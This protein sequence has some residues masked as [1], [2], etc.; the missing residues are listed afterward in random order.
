MINITANEKLTKVLKEKGVDHYGPAYSGESV[1]L[2]LYYTGDAVLVVS[3]GRVLNNETREVVKLVPTGLRVALPKKWVGLILDRGSISKTDLIRR[4]GVVDPGYTDEVFV[5]LV[6]LPLGGEY[7]IYPGDKLPV[8]MV[9]VPV[10]NEFNLVTEEE[11]TKIVADAKRKQG[12]TGS[13]D[14]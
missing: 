3:R 5:N 11:F 13:S 6:E 12:K 2:D 7:F 14:K 4:A 8:Q 9:C 1:G 10:D